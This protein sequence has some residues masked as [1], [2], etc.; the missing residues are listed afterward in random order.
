[1]L[2]VMSARRVTQTG[3]NRRDVARRTMSTRVR[4]ANLLIAI[5]VAVSAAAACRSRD[6]R[7]SASPAPSASASSSAVA[8]E[9]PSQEPPAPIFVLD[10]AAPSRSLPPPREGS[11]LARSPK[12]DALYVA[13]ED[14]SKVRVK[15]LSDLSLPA[16]HVAMPGRPA[17][18]VAT[19]D[20]VLVTIR[21][22]SLLLVMRPDATGLVEVSR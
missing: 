11:T 18:I 15:R 14:R 13:D 2:R 10:D 1:M 7:T 22:P 21:D 20:R 12:D 6:E 3:G 9:V 19:D 5:V 4:T 17:Q 8:S 16:A